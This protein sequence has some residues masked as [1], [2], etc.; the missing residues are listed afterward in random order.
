MTH[1]NLKNL[2]TLL[3]QQACW[4]VANADK[5]PVRPGTDQRICGDKTPHLMSFDEASQLIQ[6]GTHH[7]PVYFHCEQEPYST[8]DIDHGR[9]PATGK[10]ADWCKAFFQQFRFNLGYT[11]ISSSGTGYHV[12]CSGKAE[13]NKRSFFPTA[14]R[15]KGCPKFEVMSGKSLITLTGNTIEMPENRALP[16]NEALAYLNQHYPPPAPPP[17]QPVA[18]DWRN[19][20]YPDWQAG[21]VSDMLSY[22]HADCDHETWKQ[23]GMALH[24][25][26]GGSAEGHALWLGWS[27]ES[28][29]FS[30][31][32]RSTINSAWRGFTPNK[33]YNIGT[34]V[35]LAKAHGWQAPKRE[36]K[37]EIKTFNVV[38][39][40][41]TEKTDDCSPTAPRAAGVIKSEGVI[42][43]LVRR[44]NEQYIHVVHE[45]KNFIVAV[46]E[47]SNGYPAT[48]YYRLEEFRSMLSHDPAIQVGTNKDGSPKFK[49]SANVWLSHPHAN[50]IHG[51]T[52]YPV[53]ERFYRGRLN[54]Y[55]GFGVS[56]QS[57][58]PRD[59]D[60]LR[61]KRH[62]FSILCN[63]QGR[64]YRYLIRWLA[65]LVQKPEEKPGTAIIL[66]GGQGTGKNTFADPL[67][68]VMGSH[69]Q[70][71]NRPELITGR[72]N[73]AIE[74]KL[75][76]F[77][78]EA[79]FN[80]RTATNP[81]EN[82]DH[83]TVQ[84]D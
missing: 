22:L 63:H 39:I 42:G 67:L 31:K 14:Q 24:H 3:Q 18:R 41:K 32:D 16:V 5:I 68:Q 55:Y 11:E 58:D 61:W 33:G 38:P 2:S 70:Y 35:N 6:Q 52:F 76:I 62:V 77:A 27:E 73:S 26:S 15:G 83:R 78:D 23:V 19:R 13:F 44:Y 51:I 53:R 21:D 49:T 28:P 1:I 71:V 17:I 29:D 36:N 57:H 72:F 45:G 40:K 50:Y 43:S 8:I 60:L 12:L 10:P 46:G 37:R 74:N 54:T 47:A 81:T 4:L 80:S 69:G 64:L 48:I 82:H 79:M 20:D 25:W 34:L 59:D 66:K 9:D 75:L 7:W 56:P 30:G 84:H 65:H